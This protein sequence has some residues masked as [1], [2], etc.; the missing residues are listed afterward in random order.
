MKITVVELLMFSRNY[1]SREFRRPEFRV[2]TRISG[3]PTHHYTMYYTANARAFIREE[4]RLT[5]LGGKSGSKSE[6][7]RNNCVELFLK[8][9]L[10]EP[11]QALSAS[12]ESCDGVAKSRVIFDPL[13][14]WSMLFTLRITLLANAGNNVN[15]QL[16]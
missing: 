15:K 10:S 2:M 14:I 13:D 3:N 1:F 9:W 5:G 8:S 7:C 16:I 12:L 4:Q 11:S 6:L